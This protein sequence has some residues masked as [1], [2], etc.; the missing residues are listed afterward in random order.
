MIES[1]P[2]FN[3]HGEPFALP[4]NGAGW[5]VRRLRG[6]RGAP[7]LVYGQDGRPLTLDIEAG[8]D[9]LRDAVDTSGRYRLDA[10]DEHGK[11]IEDVQPSY[12]HATVT[13]R[14]SF[15]PDPA[16]SAALNPTDHAIRELV[17]ANVELVRATSDLAKSVSTQQPDL[18]KA[19]AE[20]LRAADGAGLPRREPVGDWYNEDEETDESEDSPK[21][22][23]DV[24]TLMQQLAPAIA[25]LTGMDQRAA[26]QAR[27]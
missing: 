19:A 6:G 8:M 15:M 9:E 7:E 27:C 2:A 10:I 5:R 23:F 13:P 14:N 21:P 25:K 12:V 11:A 22:A 18:M 16:A 26:S 1:E 24:P 17:R 4:D 20:I 3:Q